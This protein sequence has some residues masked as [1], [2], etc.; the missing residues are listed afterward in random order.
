MVR[1]LLRPMLREWLDA[2]LPA[3]VEEMVSREIRRITEAAR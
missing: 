1:E 3:M 2:N